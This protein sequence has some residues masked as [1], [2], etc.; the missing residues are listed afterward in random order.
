MKKLLILFLLVNFACIAY[1]D[2]LEVKT[3]VNSTDIISPD[4][5]TVNYVDPNDVLEIPYSSKLIANGLLVLNYN[6]IDIILKN[7]Q[8]IF[9]TKDPIKRTLVFSKVENSREGTIVVKFNS[10]IKATIPP[11]SVFSLMY[12]EKENSVTM[13]MISGKSTINSDEKVIDLAENETYKYFCK[14]EIVIDIT[15]EEDN[16]NAI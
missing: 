7:K 12:N 13:K 15:G 5:E 10:T 4:G 14:K 11:D 9:V 16:S 1:S 8:G 2:P 3:I 6:S